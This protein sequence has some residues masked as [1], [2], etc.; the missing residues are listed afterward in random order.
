MGLIIIIWLILARDCKISPRTYNQFINKHYC[1]LVHISFWC[2]LFYWTLPLSGPELSYFRDHMLLGFQMLVHCAVSLSRLLACPW[3]VNNDIEYHHASV[4]V[5]HQFNLTSP[6]KLSWDTAPLSQGLK[7]VF[8]N[9]CDGLLAKVG[10]PWQLWQNASVDKMQW[11]K[12]LQ[13]SF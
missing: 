12:W 13:P 6:R 7:S 10:E 9:H 3:D 11:G 2:L 5:I 4:Q 1:L 8:T